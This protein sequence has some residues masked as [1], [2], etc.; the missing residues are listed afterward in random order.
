M[1]EDFQVWIWGDSIGC[2]GVAKY[3]EGTHQ[4]KDSCALTL[5]VS[6]RCNNLS[7]FV[8]G[9]GVVLAGASTQQILALTI[10]KLRKK[11]ARCVATAEFLTC[12]WD[13]QVQRAALPDP[14]LA[15]TLGKSW[16]VFVTIRVV[17]RVVP[18]FL[19]VSFL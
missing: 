7:M 19:C 5:N 3:E 18:S 4:S 6:L 16:S 2:P 1:L 13:M 8:V 15:S 17:G 9:N 10:E 11:A 14:S 12:G